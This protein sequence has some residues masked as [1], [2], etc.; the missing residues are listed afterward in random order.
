MTSGQIS[1][2]TVSPK[3]AP[4]SACFSVLTRTQP[5][6]FMTWEYAVLREGALR[7]AGWLAFASDRILA[8]FR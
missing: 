1:V 3:I 5:V 6:A 7:P 4:N 2:M 8:S